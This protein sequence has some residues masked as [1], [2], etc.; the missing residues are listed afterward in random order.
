MEI[1]AFTIRI[2]KELH[3]KIKTVAIEQEKTMCEFVTDALREKIEE[4]QTNK[5]E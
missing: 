3:K 2:P 1:Q 5:K 4:P